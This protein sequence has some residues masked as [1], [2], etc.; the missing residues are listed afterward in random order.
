M[1][2]GVSVQ[3]HLAG[4]EVQSL[5]AALAGTTPIS[6]LNDDEKGD[7]GGES[8]SS[9]SSSNVW[10]ALSDFPEALSAAGNLE[11]E[12]SVHE[13]GKQMSQ[14]H[15]TS[16]NLGRLMIYVSRV[17]EDVNFETREVPTKA[18]NAVVLLSAFLK[19]FVEETN[20]E[21]CAWACNYAGENATISAMHQLG[22]AL[23]STAS[24]LRTKL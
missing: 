22:T 17:L 1:G 4:D 24:L 15:R 12:K 11:I 5:Y 2:N 18:I 21:E 23:L 13:Y 3:S 10:G 19:Y 20:V 6:L 8:S 14:N 9:S 7:A 16:N